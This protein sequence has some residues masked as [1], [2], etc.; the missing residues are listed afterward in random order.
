MVVSGR[1]QPPSGLGR[2]PQRQHLGVGG[3]VAAQLA[4]VALGGQDLVAARHHGADRHVAVPG[5][6]GRPLQRQPH[7]AL[8]G[9]A[10]LVPGRARRKY[11]GHWNFPPSIVFSE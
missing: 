2:R 11:R 8:V 1:R 10:E 3:R 9:F 5:G 7:H 4:L 6:R